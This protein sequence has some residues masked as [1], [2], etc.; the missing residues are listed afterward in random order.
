[1]PAE[2][3]TKYRFS[4]EERAFVIQQLSHTESVTGVPIVYRFV[5]AAG[6]ERLDVAFNLGEGTIDPEMLIFSITS[7]PGPIG[8]WY[9][10][11]Q[12]DGR[13][14]GPAPAYGLFHEV[15]AYGAALTRGT[16]DR[17]ANKLG[18]AGRSTGSRVDTETTGNQ[19]FTAHE[20]FDLRSLASR[21]GQSAGVEG[22]VEFTPMGSTACSVGFGLI[23]SNGTQLPL[24]SFVKSIDS[25]G[26]VVTVRGIKGTEIPNAPSSFTSFDSAL[27]F[28]RSYFEFASERFKAVVA[29]HK[30]SFFVN[31]KK[32]IFG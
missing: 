28:S 23:S 3:I 32:S 22:F 1:M 29:S 14:L 20:V 30:P 16:C 11:K 25:N 15:F 21:V 12:G 26:V 17:I 24:G 13:Q 5:P 19:V 31:L 7:E 4:E 10:G 8:T 6:Y 2:E 27:K 18:E 9:S